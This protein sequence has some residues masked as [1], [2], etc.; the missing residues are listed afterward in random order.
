MF[1]GMGMA[2]MLVVVIGFQMMF[3]RGARDLAQGL[4]ESFIAFTRGFFGTQ[5]GA[6]GVFIGVIASVHVLLLGYGLTW[7]A[8]W[9]RQRIGT[10]SD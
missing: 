2:L 3:S 4:V 8:W 7:L 6:V 5:Q 9:A 1:W 10:R